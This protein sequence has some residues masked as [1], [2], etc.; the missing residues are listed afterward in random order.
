MGKARKPV[1]ACPPVFPCALR[2]ESL[3]CQFLDGR[4]PP[5]GH[6]RLVVVAPSG[7]V[8][9]AELASGRRRRALCRR[10]KRVASWGGES[11]LSEGQGP[12]ETA[13]VRSGRRIRRGRAPR[14]VRTHRRA[15]HSCV[16][17]AGGSAS[18]S[19]PSPTAV[20]SAMASVQQY[21]SVLAGAQS[22]ANAD[23]QRAAAQMQI[24]VRARSPTPRDASP[25]RDAL[26]FIPPQQTQRRRVCAPDLAP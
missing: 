12:R 7:V 2:G 11:T 5:V 26:L 20:A 16:A 14:A 22:G 25:R 8:C 1:H 19:P 23:A 9:S 21:L 6:V 13:L 10:T 4:K 18:E 24:E 15:A 3:L 17:C